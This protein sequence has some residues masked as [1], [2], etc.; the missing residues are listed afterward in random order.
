M[1]AFIFIG[2]EK[3]RGSR[4]RTD[5]GEYSKMISVVDRSDPLLRRKY[6]FELNGEPV[7]VDDATAAKLA[8][9]SHFKQAAKKSA[10]AEKEPNGNL[11]GGKAAQ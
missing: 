4:V 2:D 3:G 8:G 7:E 1:A 6:T 11:D 10:R 9:N 5:D